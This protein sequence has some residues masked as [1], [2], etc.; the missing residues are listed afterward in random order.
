MRQLNWMPSLAMPRGMAI[1]A[2]L[3]TTA[4]IPMVGRVGPVD[5]QNATPVASATAKPVAS[6]TAQATNPPS[7][8]PTAFD[9]DTSTHEQ[10]V[11]QGLAIFDITPAIWRV[12]EV[13]MPDEADAESIARDASFLIQMEGT[14]VVRNDVT[15]KRALLEPGEA[16]FM[17][18]GD[19][20]TARAG[21]TSRSL[22]WLIEYVPADASDDDAGGTVI[23]KTNAIDEF[24]DGARDLEVIRNSLFPGETAPFP[25][26]QGSALVLVTSGT[27]I[28]SA[29]AGTSALKQGDGLLLP[30]S[31][32]LTNN[33]D[34]KA[35]YVIVLIGG[36]VG[37]S[38]SSGEESTSEDEGGATPTAVAEPTVTATATTAPPNDDA[39]NDGL[40][41]DEEA[42]LGTDPAKADTDGDGLIDRIEKDYTDPLNPD[43]D[44][45]GTSDGDEDLIYGTD[46]NDPNSKP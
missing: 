40:T 1:V 23:Y 45:D 17:S 41:D 5:A 46:P 4:L 27:V 39:D 13:E 25:K 20:Y 42:A 36:K 31:V 14:T 8:S 3:M 33:T 6:P 43:T 44:G 2:M 12:T 15:T 32:T 7:A 18:G 35:T 30:G 37:A 29:G 38:T 9:P 11:A 16:Y 19:A 34:G 10:V 21:G 28:A 22:A 24:P 26:H